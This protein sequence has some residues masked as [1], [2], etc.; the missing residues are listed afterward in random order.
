MLDGLFKPAWQSSSAAKR[1]EAISRLD[2]SVQE[3][4][5]ALESLAKDDAELNVRKA[6]LEKLPIQP[7]FSA[8]SSHSDEKTRQHAK[9]ILSN[10]NGDNDQINEAA[11]RTLI[12]KETK[13]LPW[14]VK[15]CPF[16]EI[17]NDIAS[18]LSESELLQILGEVEYSE[19]RKLIAERFETLELLEQARKELQGKDKN[20]ER[21]I[22]SKI[23]VLRDQ[24]KQE[25]ENRLHAEDLCS[26]MEHLASK[27]EWQAEYGR[28]YL[29][30]RNQ[31]DSM[32]FTP[33]DEMQARYQSAFDLV[34]IKFKQQE[35]ITATQSSQEELAENLQAF[36][37]E[38]ASYSKADLISNDQKL[39]DR[40]SQDQKAWD[41]HLETVP[42]NLNIADQFTKAKKALASLIN[43]TSKLQAIGA[44]QLQE[45]QPGKETEEAGTEIE[46]KSKQ[47]TNDQNIQT[48]TTELK[49]ALSALKWPS[50][51]PLLN[52]A[53]E[54]QSELDEIST[55]IKK[56][57]KEKQ[58]TLDK[59]HK[60]INRILGATKRGE[61]GRAKRELG[62][63]T[64][65]ALAYSG[66]D[67]SALDSRIEKASEV[68]NKM[69]DWK[70]FATEPKY[71]ELCNGMEALVGSTLHPEQLSKEIQTLQQQW[72]A[73]G[74]S[75]ASE[76]YWER[77]KEA[78][79]NAYAPCTTF[80]SERRSA[81]KANLAERE[82][83]V[84]RT[85]NLLDET[86][87][88]NQPDYKNIEVK[89]RSLMND[90]KK[91]K[92]VEQGPGQ[93]QWKRF[94]H[95][96]SEINSK[97][98]L[99]YDANIELKH[100]LIDQ[101]KVFAESDIKEESLT[102]LQL[103]QTR[104]KQI[105]VTR[106]KDDQAA[107]G[108]FKSVTDGIYEKIQGVRQ[109]KNN[110]EKA[111]LDGYNSIVKRIRAL[112]KDARD[113][114]ESDHLFKQLQT[115][116]E[117]L[118]ALKKGLPEKL[119][120]NLERDYQRA[121]DAYSKSRDRMLDASDKEEMQSLIEKARLCTELEALA[122]SDDHE[123]IDQL[124]SEI[125]DIEIRDRKTHKLFEQRLA[126]ALDTDK[127]VA[128]EQRKTLCIELEILM[129][130][131]S[132]DEDRQQ[133]MKIQ[134]DRMQTQGLGT[135]VGDTKAE[136]TERKVQWLCVAG[137]ETKLQSALD[138]RFNKLF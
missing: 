27:E 7:L 3:D 103:M 12:S 60:R 101:A 79:D 1:L 120:D 128:G 132:P 47:S 29:V 62:S 39:A 56:Y 131:P 134:F 73:L 48:E 109:E 9:A 116:Y 57:N 95:I 100:A 68:I 112:A 76:K 77:F 115:E 98:S 111:Q 33:E 43:F 54:V 35:K 46:N 65:S 63:I 97:L 55:K 45:Q 137:A 32:A 24:Q 5:A 21:I 23:D 8:F 49:H 41:T 105:G 20:A 38:L 15:L 113:L 124:R 118:P 127:T 126:A 40:L 130:K 123:R 26:K 138:E 34:S 44:T 125:N 121:C 58:D 117:N 14:V 107:W 106:R 135:G 94:S 61:I 37:H 110:E 25:T 122:G 71:I 83:L 92:D 133:R 67:K 70:D 42:A 93:K 52:A 50:T 11:Y 75:D 136:I 87:W 2:P 88:D 6:A 30:Y 19:T 78:G 104:W 13:A 108:E 80:F 51:Y 64:K 28:K 53:S 86:D 69:G 36:C 91:I 90:W 59:L 17:R 102:Q 85:Q 99:V 31:W 114:A 72:K 10:T 96:R 119:V 4:C 18:K 22:K 89:M 16:A 82:Q 129:E 81:R 74:Y 84:T 66:K